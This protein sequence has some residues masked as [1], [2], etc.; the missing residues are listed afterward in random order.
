MVNPHTGLLPL[1][2]PRAIDGHGNVAN[3]TTTPSSHQIQPALC[4]HSAPFSNSACQNTTTQWQ[5]TV[6]S[7]HG[8]IT[9]FQNRLSF[10]FLGVCYAPQPRRFTYSTPYK[11][12]SSSDATSLRF[13]THAVWRRRLGGLSISQHMQ[14][15][16][17]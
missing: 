16:N 7:N 9:G 5:V 3:T 12:T 8:Y 15:Q 4:T 1:R 13:T 11:G 10:R 14:V 2:I 6:H 17:N